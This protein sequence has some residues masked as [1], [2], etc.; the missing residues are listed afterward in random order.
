MDGFA[1]EAFGGEELERAVGRAAR[2]REQTSAT[3][4]A[5]IRTTI[6]SRR[7]CALT[8]SAMTSRRRRSRRRG[9]P[10]A[11]GMSCRFPSCV[12]QAGKRLDVAH[13]TVTC[14]AAVCDGA[15]NRV[16]CNQALIEAV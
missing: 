5:A 3:M 11:L 9:P 15:V 8:G 7:A 10:R 16:V 14:I 13:A 1:V 6:L 4:L 12:G 2:R